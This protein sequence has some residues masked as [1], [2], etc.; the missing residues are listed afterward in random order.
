MSIAHHHRIEYRAYHISFLAVLEVIEQLPV[1]DDVFIGRLG[2]GGVGLGN[3]RKDL[4]L[5]FPTPHCY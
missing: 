4:P 1:G 2:R 5:A 3:C